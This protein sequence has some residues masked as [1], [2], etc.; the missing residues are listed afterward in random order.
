[1]EGLSTPI[2]NDTIGCQLLKKM[3]WTSGGLGQEGNGI[4]E[5]LQIHIKR[6]TKGIGA[7][8]QQSNM[9]CASMS[10]IKSTSNNSS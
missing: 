4:E 9:N 1:M 8:S 5:P 6:D 3:G 7:S 10:F 2:G